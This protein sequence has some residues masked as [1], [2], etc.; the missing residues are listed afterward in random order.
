[1]PVS[2]SKYTLVMLFAFSLVGIAAA[3]IIFVDYYL[4]HSGTLP[5][6]SITSVGA[7]DAVVQVNCIAV[8]SSKFDEVLGIPLD[9][10]A[11]AWFTINLFFILILITN[12][13][14]SKGNIRR[15]QQFMLAWAIIG[16]AVVPYLVYLEIDVL[17][18][19]CLYCTT[20][21]IAIILDFLF[22]VFA[23][24]KSKR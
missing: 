19:L 23:F 1:M 8:I 24:L 14:K 15:I 11:L 2:F 9:F 17:K 7:A 16:I 10:L 13:V 18:S 4:M 5:L 21:H 3:G 12:K 6:C 22:V 20:M